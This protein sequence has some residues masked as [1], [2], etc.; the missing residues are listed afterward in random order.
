MTRRV[1]IARVSRHPL[2]KAMREGVV[3]LPRTLRISLRK[4]PDGRWDFRYTEGFD[5][6]VIAHHPEAVDRTLA[7]VQDFLRLFAASASVEASAERA[8]LYGIRLRLVCEFN[9]VI[10]SIMGELSAIGIR[11]EGLSPEGII[12]IV[13]AVLMA[14]APAPSPEARP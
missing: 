3:L 11:Q 6:K 7:S 13:S 2:V 14:T 10:G 1:P 5:P 4:L 12:G 9:A 8:G